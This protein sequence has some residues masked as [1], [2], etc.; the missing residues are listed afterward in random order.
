MNKLLQ[1]SYVKKLF[2]E[3]KPSSKFIELL[4]HGNILFFLYLTC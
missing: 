3:Q 4:I 2:K 1:I